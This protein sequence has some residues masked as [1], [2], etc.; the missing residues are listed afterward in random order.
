MNP[1][2][3]DILLSFLSRFNQI[4]VQF[5][6]PEADHLI[7]QAIGRRPDALYLL[8]QKAVLQEM[9]LQQAEQKIQELEN[10]LRA[11]QTTQKPVQSS[12]FLGSVFGSGSSTGRRRGGWGDDPDTTVASN[13]PIQNRWDSGY[14]PPPPAPVQPSRGGGMGGFLTAAAAT[15]AGVAGGALLFQGVKSFF[16]GNE[17]TPIQASSYEDAP[18]ENQYG[19]TPPAIPSEN[20]FSAEEAAPDFSTD[21]GGDDSSWV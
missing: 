9:A 2:E 10:A 21:S 1:Q 4:P 17:S 6:E 18:S 16:G 13:P 15:A 12:G 7:R 3:R 14:A 19:D 20:S 11:A 5:P 8:V